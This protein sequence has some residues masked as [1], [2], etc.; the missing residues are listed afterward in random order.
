MKF[1]LRI[2][3]LL[4]TLVGMAAAVLVLI[5]LSGNYPALK[6]EWYWLGSNEIML[7]AGLA[8]ILFGCGLGF[9]AIK[10]K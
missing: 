6:K 9:Y 5:D 4:C 7:G 2:V 8:F 3:A 10:R 1:L